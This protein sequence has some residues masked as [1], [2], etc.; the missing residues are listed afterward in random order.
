ME[1]SMKGTRRGTAVAYITAMHQAYPAKVLSVATEMAALGSPT[2]RAI[3]TA[4]GWMA[5]EGVHRLAAAAKLGRPINIAP[6]E[7]DT[8]DLNTLDWDDNGW[9]EDRT[10]APIAEA[11]NRMF[12]APC[13]AS[14]YLNNFIPIQVRAVTWAIPLI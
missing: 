3:A 10:A 7:G 8:I 4:N 1:D 5:L 2:I 9:F 14:Y 6:V 13:G 11:L 12:A